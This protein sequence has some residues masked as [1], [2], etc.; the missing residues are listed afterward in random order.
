LKIIMAQFFVSSL[1]S[2]FSTYLCSKI[3]KER[4]KSKG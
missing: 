2:S 3:N 4:G 1:K